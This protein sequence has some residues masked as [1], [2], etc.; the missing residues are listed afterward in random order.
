MHFCELNTNQT[1]LEGKMERIHLL[2]Q[3]KAASVVEIHFNGVFK[4]LYMCI[5][6]CF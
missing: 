1:C 4:H 5:Y 2:K 6:L 3:F